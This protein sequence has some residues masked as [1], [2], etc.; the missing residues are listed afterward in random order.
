MPFSW[1]AIRMGPNWRLRHKRVRIVAFLGV[2]NGAQATKI[3]GS[4]RFLRKALS[5]AMIS[6]MSKGR[7]IGLDSGSMYLAVNRFRLQ[8]SMSRCYL[9]ARSGL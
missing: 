9:A 7:L 5:F 3:T 2:S 4:K 8:R 1:D 6:L